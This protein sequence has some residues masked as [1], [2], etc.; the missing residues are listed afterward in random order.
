[1][2]TPQKTKKQNTN[3][4]VTSQNI[5]IILFCIIASVVIGVHTGDLII[6][7]ILLATGLINS[8]LTGLQKR[9]GYILGVINALLLA[10]VGLKNNFFGSFS[11]NAFIIA[12]LEVIGFL[13]WSQNLDKKK[14]TIIRKLSLR[15]SI[16]LVGSCIVGSI[17]FGYLLTLIPDQNMAFLDSTICC[18]DICA[19]VIMNLRY[20]ESWWLWILSGILSVIMWA[21]AL[22][23]GGENAFMRLLAAIGFLSTSIYGAIKWYKK[24]K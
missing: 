15:N 14:N 9:S 11:I 22:A 6:G 24:L 21:I 8:Y 23:E 2:K 20:E 17:V 12:P 4:K 13:A 16:I 5:T 10:Y 3:Q 1:M 18:I 7:S 19:L